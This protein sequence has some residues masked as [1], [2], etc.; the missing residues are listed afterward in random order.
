MAEPDQ[1]PVLQPVAVTLERDHL[2]MVHQAVDHG[3][4]HHV[5]AEHLS[6]PRKLNRS[7]LPDVH[8]RWRHHSH[9][10]SANRITVEHALADRKRWKQLM[11]WSHRCE[12]LLA[13]YRA[14][15]GLVSG[16]TTNT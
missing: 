15:A 11:R 1:I 10:H 7:A 12:S 16:R 3:R 5:I 14:I 9:S 2:R 13:T 4:G 6:P 8:E